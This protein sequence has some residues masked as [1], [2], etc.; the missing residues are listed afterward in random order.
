MLWIPVLA[1]GYEVNGEEFAGPPAP[2]P[3]QRGLMY[4][5]YKWG[6]IASWLVGGVMCAGLT[7]VAL[8]HSM[9]FNYHL[10]VTHGQFAFWAVEEG[11]KTWDKRK[12]IGIKIKC[13]KENASDSSA[14]ADILFLAWWPAILVMLFCWAVAAVAGIV[15]PLILFAGLPYFVIRTIAYKKRKKVVFV[16]KLKD[17]DTNGLI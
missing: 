9:R 12:E 6:V 8:W 15:W 4:L 16:D 5:I 17:N 13:I 11:S 7:F 3:V 10:Y 1:F 2:E 14:S